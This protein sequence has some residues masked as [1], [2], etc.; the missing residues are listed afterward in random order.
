M[1]ITT[2]RRI[3]A[4]ALLATMAFAACSSSGAS[5]APS[6]AATTA[7]TTAPTTAESMAPSTGDASPSAA[8]SGG[9]APSNAANCVAGSITAGGS[10]ALQPLVDKVGKDYAALCAG[11]TISVQGGGSGTGLTQ[12]AAGTFQIGNSDV[13]AGSSLRRPEVGS[14]SIIRSRSRDG[15]RSSTPA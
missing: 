4:L 8:A 14:W 12:V 1:M 2:P 11:S 15:F 9:P 10:T 13:L 7:P 5:T 6:A 3:G